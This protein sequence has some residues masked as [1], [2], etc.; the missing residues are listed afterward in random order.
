MRFSLV[1]RWIVLL[2]GVTLAAEAQGLAGFEKRITTK[3]LPNGRTLIVC[4]RPEAPVFS[5]FTIVDAGDAN[6]PGG[7]SGLAHMFE[8]LAFKGTKD[9]G[10]TDYAAEKVALDK[11]EAAYA[12][13]DTEYRKRVGQDPAK[14]KQLKADFDAAEQEANKYVIPNEFTEI[15]E[16]NGA[17]GLNAET[18]LDATQYFWSMPS[19]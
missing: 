7:Q 19:N 1:V 2:C 11:V 17:S 18:S 12:A 3:V 9:I 5:Y 13:Y 16:A 8:H 15:A 14:L 6:D 4:E 10:T